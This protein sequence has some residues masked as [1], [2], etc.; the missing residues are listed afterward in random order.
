MWNYYHSWNSV[1]LFLLISSSNSSSKTAQACT[2]F[3]VGKDASTDGSVLVSHS[4]D[5][6]FDTDPRLVKVPSRTYQQGSQRPVYFSPESYPRYVGTAR[7]IPEYFPKEGQED[8]VP[9]GYIDQPTT[10]TA[11]ST[12]TTT[13]IEKMEATILRNNNNNN[14]K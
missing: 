5:G 8:F 2:V 9:L 6:E 3:I 1:V 11:T 10:A 13:K 7:G 12:T 4:N 14:H